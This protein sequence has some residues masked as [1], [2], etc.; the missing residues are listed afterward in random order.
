VGT[1]AEPRVRVRAAA[2]LAASASTATAFLAF[3]VPVVTVGLPVAG[4]PADGDQ[5]RVAVPQWG[6]SKAPDCAGD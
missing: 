3:T 1:R 2:L 6:V 5:C 4:Y